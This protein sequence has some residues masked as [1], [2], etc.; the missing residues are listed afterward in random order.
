MNT[1]TPAYTPCIHAH[2]L[3]YIHTCMGKLVGYE[4]AVVRWIRSS[5]MHKVK[6]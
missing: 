6:V 3:T 2:T 4:L 5:P 1:Y